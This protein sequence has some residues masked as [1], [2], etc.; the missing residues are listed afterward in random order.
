M[1][2]CSAV[3]C[4]CCCCFFF[5]TLFQLECVALCDI[6]PWRTVYDCN[7]HNR[8][9]QCCPFGHN[10]TFSEK[11]CQLSCLFFVITK[12]R[13]I[14]KT[15]FGTFDASISKWSNCLFEIDE[16]FIFESWLWKWCNWN[17]SFAQ[18]NLITHIL[19]RRTTY[20]LQSLGNKLKWMSTERVITVKHLHGCCSV[21][22][23]SHP[24]SLS[25]ITKRVWI[26]F[27]TLF[28]FVSLSLALCTTR[29]NNAFFCVEK[30]YNGSLR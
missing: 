10:L 7:Y 6:F 16:W 3:T 2:L 28:L 15:T 24:T 26:S 4:K 27:L 17:G 30:L 29:F 14:T 20:A 11:I 18:H 22:K 12:K 19:E 5:I 1:H 9:I 25:S 21:E 8:K 13:R 23:G